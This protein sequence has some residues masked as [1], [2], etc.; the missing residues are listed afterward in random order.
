MQMLLALMTDKPAGGLIGFLEKFKTAGLGPI[1][2]S[3][4]GGGPA[5]QP[6][7]NSQ[8]ETVLGGGDDKLSMLTKRLGLARDD[9]TSAL[10]YLLPPIVGKLTLGGSV[11]SKLPA[12]VV[13]LADVG[14]SLL[15]MPVRDGAK[16]SSGAGMIKWLPWAIVVL[17]VLIGLGY[18]VGNRNG[19]TSSVTPLVSTS[20]AKPASSSE[21]VPT[22]SAASQPV[23][24]GGK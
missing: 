12:E 3:W 22:A 18:Y 8:L 13:S 17:A 14:Q 16:D 2:Q 5:A 9:V 6:I 7:S 4:L 20:D 23:A 1:V 24:T 10:A 15:S 19:N 11:L 21:P